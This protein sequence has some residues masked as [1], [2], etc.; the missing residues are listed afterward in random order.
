MLSL[1]G[2]VTNT[3]KGVYFSFPVFYL[4]SIHMTKSL[5]SFSRDDQTD[6]TRCVHSVLFGT[7]VWG[8]LPMLR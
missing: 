1:C 3:G 2:Y 5:S 6:I 7:C 4:G 8:V